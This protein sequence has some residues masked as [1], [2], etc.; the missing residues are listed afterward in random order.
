MYL[1]FLSKTLTFRVV[2]TRLVYFEV[3]TAREA[4]DNN[5]SDVPALPL[6][7]LWEVI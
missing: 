4:V 1:H 2:K 6:L 5:I 7:Q 3:E